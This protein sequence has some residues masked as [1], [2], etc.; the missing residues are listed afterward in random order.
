MQEANKQATDPANLGVSCAS[1]SPW[2]VCYTKPCAE[3]ATR[4]RIQEEGGTAW[5]P[6]EPPPK[7]RA[8]ER[9][10]TIRP[11]F[12][13]YVFVRD[14]RWI[15]VR[16]AGG[17]EMASILTTPTRRPL[18][19]PSGAVELLMTL[20]DPRGVMHPPTVREV[21]FKDTVRIETGPFA[22]F[23]GICQRTTRDRVW[24]LLNLLGRPT[25]VPF[26]R[27]QVELIS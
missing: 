15:V 1:N 16:N 26:T 12:P 19:L 21:T 3:A 14:Y 25:E 20:C 11:L 8:V 6:L 24:I 13:R 9:E 27:Q 5:L 22:D 7:R 4:H 23:V 18:K 10:R 2:F 17:E